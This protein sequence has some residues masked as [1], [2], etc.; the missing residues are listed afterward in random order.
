[1]NDKVLS[2]LEYT[3]IIE[4]L[5]EKATSAPG[6]ELCRNLSP[7]T[8]LKAIELAQT[9]TSDALTMLFQKGSTSFGGN[10]DISMGL[11]SLEI[12]STLSA[13]E[14]LK[15]AGLLDNVNRIKAY[16]RSQQDDEKETSLTGY[17]ERLEPLTLLSGEIRRCILSEEEIADDASPT[18]KH[19]RRSIALT[20]EKIHSQ[21]T[22]MVNGSCRNYLQDAVITMR[23]NRYC[24]PV[25]S[26]YKNQV[27]GMVHDQSST[28]STF[29]I[30]PAA[31]VELNN[32]LKELSVQEKKKLKCSLPP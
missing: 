24:I 28:G 30:E 15:I 21:L 31:V 9:E 13:A 17:F 16:G 6:R 27:P 32:H 4:L 20:G 22:S 29:F 19:I 1:M 18:L 3:K 12:G 10:K 2:T 11:R 25:K 14:L 23:D 5:T 8:D 7:M 26:E